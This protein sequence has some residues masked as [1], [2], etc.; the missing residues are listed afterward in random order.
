M[1]IRKKTLLFLMISALITS[2]L[3]E[4]SQIPFE[5]GDDFNVSVSNGYSLGRYKAGDTIYVYSRALT[6]FEVFE[7]WVINN[8]NI[9]FIEDPSEWKFSFIMPDENVS[10]EANISN[11][12]SNFLLFESIEL[13][14]SVK[15]I[16]SAFPE[17]AIGTVFIF[18]G[19]GGSA[20]G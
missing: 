11:L 16:F 12:S 20:E 2:C 6:E 1:A 10:L 4:D 14:N 7:S 13:S 5:P 9:E 18:H 3:K 15:P 19:T 17:N 8:S